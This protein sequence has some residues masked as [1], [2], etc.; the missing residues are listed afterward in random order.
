MEHELEKGFREKIEEAEHMVVSWRRERV[1]NQIERQG[2][3]PRRTWYPAAAAVGAI[4]LVAGVVQ[5]QKKELTRPGQ[6]AVIPDR[7]KKPPASQRMRERPLPV[8]PEIPVA[9]EPVVEP[10]PPVSLPMTVIA[11]SPPPDTVLVLQEV[12]PIVGRIPQPEAETVTLRKKKIQFKLHQPLA[13]PLA[14]DDQGLSARL[15]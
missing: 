7:T 10:T 1:W 12:K 15:K 8:Q 13:L 5:Q 3:A 2:S 4:L 9:P 11:E 14:A 6:V